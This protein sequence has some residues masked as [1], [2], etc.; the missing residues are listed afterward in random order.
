M[1]RVRAGSAVR[2]LWP[3][4]SPWDWQKLAASATLAGI[5]GLGDTIH[6]NGEKHR[7]ALFFQGRR[8]NKGLRA[9]P[10]MPANNDPIIFFLFRL[11]T[12]TMVGV[13]EL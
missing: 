10:A 6:L 9:A 2:I 3:W 1:M 11:E 4:T 5:S 13:Q 7:D 12:P 8:Q